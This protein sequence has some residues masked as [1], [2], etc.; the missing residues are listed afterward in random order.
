M[1][2]LVTPKKM[3]PIISWDPCE[4]EFDGDYEYVMDDLSKVL[5]EINPTNQ[6]WH[7][8]VENFGWQKKSGWTSIHTNDGAKF[9]SC[10]L[11]KTECSFKIYKY[12]NTLTIKNS[13]HDS[14]Y[15]D[16]TYTIRKWKRGDPV[17]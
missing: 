4:A 15:G 9:L 3:L 16:E 8:V 2:T 7:C 10:V 1:D 17:R 5:N 12:R 11:P 6:P 14:P 13:H